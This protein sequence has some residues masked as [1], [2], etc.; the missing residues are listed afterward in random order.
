[1]ANLMKLRH[2]VGDM[3][4]IADASL[5]E[6]DMLASATPLLGDLLKSDDWLPDQFAQANPDRYQ[7]YLLYCDPLERFSLVSFVWD[8]GQ[9]TPIHDHTVWG[10]I[11]VLRGSEVSNRYEIDNGNL[12]CTSEQEILEAGQIDAVSPNIG[13]IHKVWNGRRTG[14]SVSIHLYGGNIGQI[15][16]HAFGG[17][18]SEAKSFT[19]GYSLPVIPNIF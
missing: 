1:M 5:A 14:P 10:L 12:Q 13:D 17:Q 15:T 7:Q 6:A 9:C 18:A 3:T 8:V 19:S 4:R 11:G 2:F 16:R